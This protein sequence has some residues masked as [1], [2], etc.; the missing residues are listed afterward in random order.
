MCCKVQTAS[1]RLVEI[2][3]FRMHTVVVKTIRVTGRLQLYTA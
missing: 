2:N 3:E 1:K